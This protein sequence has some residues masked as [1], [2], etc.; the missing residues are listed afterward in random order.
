M[1]DFL[2]IRCPYFVVARLSFVFSITKSLNHY[3]LLPVVNFVALT[4]K[5]DRVY[6][7]CKGDARA[8]GH[9]YPQKKR[10]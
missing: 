6:G 7:K 3:F 2:S 9:Q 8:E 1:A 10:L 4:G 5:S